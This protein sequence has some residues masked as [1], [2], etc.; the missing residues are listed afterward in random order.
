MQIA[1]AK[2]LFTR[3]L[4]FFVLTVINHLSHCD[5]LGVKQTVTTAATDQYLTTQHK[6]Q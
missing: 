5:N 4:Q 6:Q 2:Y 1:S 3:Q